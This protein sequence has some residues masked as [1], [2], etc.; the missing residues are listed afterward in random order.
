MGLA[1]SKTTKTVFLTLRLIYQSHGNFCDPVLFCFFSPYYSKVFKNVVN[2]YNMNIVS[3]CLFCLGYTSAAC[4]N[5]A[6]E[7]SV[8]QRSFAVRSLDP[9]LEPCVQRS[10]LPSWFDI[11][12][13]LQKISRFVTNKGSRQGKVRRQNLDEAC[14]KRRYHTG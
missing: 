8:F 13:W 4:S 9:G 1:W 6:Q 10:V 2:S 11:R 5:L 12:A 7:F 3:P 14:L